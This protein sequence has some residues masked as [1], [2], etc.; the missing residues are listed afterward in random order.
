MILQNKITQSYD[1]EVSYDPL[2]S[3]KK[4]M[5]DRLNTTFLKHRA[6]HKYKSQNEDF[7]NNSKQP[8]HITIPTQEQDDECNIQENV[9]FRNKSA[10][11]GQHGNFRTVVK[12]AQQVY[13]LDDD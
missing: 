7:F 13:N 11:G 1:D 8:T 5:F 3:G 6:V 2:V 12:R 4:F 9:I 10:S